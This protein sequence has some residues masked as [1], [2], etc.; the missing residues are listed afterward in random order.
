MKFLGWVLIQ[1]DGCPYRKRRL[2]HKHTERRP[3]TATGRTQLS[4]SQA[5][6]SWKKPVLRA[7]WSQFPASVIVVSATQSLVLC[8]GFLKKL[9]QNDKENRYNMCPINKSSKGA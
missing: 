2:R 5:E 6:S 9:I 4:T 3:C 1:Y 7:P 8:Y